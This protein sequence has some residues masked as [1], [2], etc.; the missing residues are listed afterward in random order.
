[1]VFSSPIFLFLFLPITL[2][3]YFVLP[4]RVRNI[5]LLAASLVFYGWGEPKFLVVMLASI[6]CNFLLALRIARLADRRRARPVL[7]AAVAVNVGLLVIFKYTDFI[8]RSLDAGLVALSV[9][10]LPVPAIALPIGI[11]F[12]TFHALSYVIDVY[13]G[14]AR[15][16]RNPFDMG[17]YI[18]LFSQLIAG[19]IIRYHDIAAQLRERD[20]TRELFA[21]GVQRFIVGLGKKVLIA[22][23]VAVSADLI[24]TIPGDQLTMGL[25]WLGVLCYA[26]QIYFDFSGYSDMAIGLGLMFGFR[27]LENFNY[28]YISQSVTEFWRRWHISLS[29][30]FRD[31]LYI[32]LGGNRVAPWRVYL[33]LLIVFFLCGLWHGASWTFVVWGLFHGAFL[34][35]ERIG[36][37]RWMAAWP[38]ALRHAY[39]LLVVMVSWVLFRADSL[40]AAG[41]FLAA[42]AGL[43]TASGIE[44]P[45]ALYADRQIVLA[46]AVGIV[47]SAPVVPAARRWLE[48]FTGRGAVLASSIGEVATLACLLAASIILLAAG[49]YNPFIYFR[50]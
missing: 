25:A 9:P 35:I 34:V 32:P 14:D 22:N 50:F 45:I 20:V 28:P 37:K 18:S 27:F 8:V 29:N 16:L 17:L 42:M 49:T 10:P 21:R 38:Q 6:A 40:S 23:T 46:I 26:L 1:M 2:G 39:L 47:G 13:R 24:F 7:I 41:H 48:R 3:V 19:P 4:K 31:Y 30:W 33:N 36:L 44:H 11:S 15:A 12:F 43:S 5:W